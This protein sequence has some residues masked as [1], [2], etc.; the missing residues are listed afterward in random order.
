[1]SGPADVV[2]DGEEPQ[3]VRDDGL[4]EEEHRAEEDD[5]DTAPDDYSD[6]ASSSEEREIPEPQLVTKR[7]VKPVVRL[8]YDEP[9]KARD[10]PITIVHRGVTIKIGKC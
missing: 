10:Q 7:R 8:T 3:N 4:D 2:P 1:M 5:L 9:G 6:P